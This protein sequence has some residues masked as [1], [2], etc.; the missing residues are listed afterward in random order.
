MTG[1]DKNLQQR[2]D[3]N[4]RVRYTNGLTIYFANKQAIYVTDGKVAIVVERWFEGNNIFKR[5]RNL[6]WT[7]SYGN[8]KSIYHAWEIARHHEIQVHQAFHFPE[9]DK[10]IPIVKEKQ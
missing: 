8:V 5:W 1:R 6:A 4:P 3:Y 10:N 9:I 7:F 2:D